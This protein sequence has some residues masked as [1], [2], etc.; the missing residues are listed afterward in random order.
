[1][2]IYVYIYLCLYLCICVYFTLI[3]IY[4]S[5]LLYIYCNGCVF[6]SVCLTTCLDVLYVCMYTRDGHVCTYIGHYVLDMKKPSHQLFR[7]KICFM[8]D[9][10]V[11][12]LLIVLLFVI[13]HVNYILLGYL[14]SQHVSYN[15]GRTLT[16]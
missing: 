14:V 1:M 2:C 8:N 13:Y 4:T 15:K 11:R 3:N 10:E 16:V 5:C 6:K 7:R 9:E 12:T